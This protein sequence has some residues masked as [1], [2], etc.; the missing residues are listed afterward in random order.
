MELIQ[1]SPAKLALRRH[2]SQE[3]LTVNHHGQPSD[4]RNSLN[5]LATRNVGELINSEIERTLLQETPPPGVKNPQMT[6]A[7]S[8]D[9][10]SPISRPGSAETLEGL[11]YPHPNVQPLNQ[12][13]GRSSVLQTRRYTP[14]ALP[15]AEMKPYHESFF[16][17]I[18]PPSYAPVEGLAASLSSACIFRTNEVSKK[19]FNYRLLHSIVGKSC[20]GERGVPRTV[21]CIG[22]KNLDAGADVEFSVNYA[23]QGGARQP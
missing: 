3:K 22:D 6:M 20:T 7:E 5:V 15:R 4:E 9:V 12:P 19:K 10:Y 11:A 17:D 13:H 21:E 16:S 2:L 14:V 23:R 1:V 18:K 8:R